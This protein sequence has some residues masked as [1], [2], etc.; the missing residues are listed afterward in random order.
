[1]RSAGRSA[2]EGDNRGVLVSITAQ[3]LAAL[4]RAQD[5]HYTGLRNRHCAH[6]SGADIAKLTATILA[7]NEA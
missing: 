7:A 5:T 2:V 3:G 1:M 6:L 4:R